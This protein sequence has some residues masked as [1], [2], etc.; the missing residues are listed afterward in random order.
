MV[1]SLAFHARN[2]GSN[3]GGSK[4]EGTLHYILNNKYVTKKK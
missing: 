1:R 4:E 3:P 2:S